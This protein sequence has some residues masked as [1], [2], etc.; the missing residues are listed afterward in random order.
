MWSESPLDRLRHE[1]YEARRAVLAMLPAPLEHL[2]EGFYGSQTWT[3]LDAWERD[4]GEAV[5]ATAAVLSREEGSIL[6]PRAYCPVCRDG[7]SSPYDRGF[8][9]PEGLRRH[10]H[11]NGNTVQC[12]VT[13][14]I[15]GLARDSR[16]EKLEAHRTEEEREREA[17]RRRRLETEISF[18]LSP[19]GTP[20]LREPRFQEMPRD[21]ESLAWAEA[22]LQVLG[23]EIGQEGMVRSYTQD[24]PGVVVYADPRNEGSITFMIYRREQ[25]KR[26]RRQSLRPHSAT[27][28]LRDS[29]R[30]DLPGKYGERFA[31]AV[32][33]L[34]I[35]GVAVVR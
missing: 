32:H 1:L 12:L 22:R 8:A 23:F 4:F 6:Q 18:R 10:L 25:P 20:Q 11:G 15:F 30:N 2:A 21:D 26:R 24:H 5:I 27:F 33:Q 3:E 14:A 9:L 13:R 34:G 7:S 28:N 16:R 17:E 31:K 35:T 19:D 29:I